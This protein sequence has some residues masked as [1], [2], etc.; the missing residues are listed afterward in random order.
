MDLNSVINLGITLLVI[1][2]VA[3]AI[4]WLIITAWFWFKEKKLK[5][6][7]PSKLMQ[8]VINE[9]QKALGLKD[10]RIPYSIEGTPEREPR[11]ERAVGKASDTGTDIQP[12][13]I[14]SVDDG[15]DNQAEGR[16]KSNRFRFKPI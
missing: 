4:G 5:S 13:A 3:G 15:R 14:Q 6:H 9:K 8:E 11:I 1:L 10:D 7:I 12:D 2:L 16:D